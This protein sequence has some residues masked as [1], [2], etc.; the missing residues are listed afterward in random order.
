MGHHFSDESSE[1]DL[2][3]RISEASNGPGK[4]DGEGISIQF[5]D[6]TYYSC[7]YTCGSTC[8]CGTGGGT[9]T[10]GNTCS[11]TCNSCNANADISLCPCSVH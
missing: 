6:P 10:C 1:F 9:N 7:N 4:Q 2:D 8:G 3:I 11:Y 5:C